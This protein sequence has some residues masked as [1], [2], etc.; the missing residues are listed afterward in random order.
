MD[1]KWEVTFR[2]IVA[3]IDGPSGQLQRP[4]VLIATWTVSIGPQCATAA[5]MNGQRGHFWG[6]SACHVAHCIPNRAHFIWYGETLPFVYQLSLK[7]A[8]QNGQFD[9][10]VLHHDGSF[11]RESLDSRLCAGVQT[12]LI[13][14]AAVCEQL[15]DLGPGLV[16]LHG[17]LQAPAARANVLRMALLA[18]EGGVYLDTDAVCVRPFGTLLREGVVCGEEHILFPASLVQ[19]HAPLAWSKSLALAGIRL[20]LRET[21]GGF[22]GFRKIEGW[23]PRAVNNAVVASVPQHP[24]VAGMLKAMLDMPEARKM[25][26]FAL[27]THLLQERVAAFEGDGLKV[28]SPEH[29]YPLPPEISQHWFRAQQASLSEVIRPETRVVHW[30]AS[31]RVADVTDGMTAEFISRHQDRVLFCKLVSGLL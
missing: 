8:F 2:Q 17:R 13:D 31:V 22:R 9:E 14:M 15:G 12:R 11:R 16:E 30:Y 19:S 4:C 28:C 29:F 21:P 5:T 3:K 27:G 7:A 25:R 10:V 20:A 6:S 18:A 26:R 24:F 23:F 1:Q